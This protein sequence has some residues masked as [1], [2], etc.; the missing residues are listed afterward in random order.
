MN[1]YIKIIILFLIFLSSCA[2]KQNN[3]VIS[4]NFSNEEWARFDYL[5]GEFEITKA[6]AV[7]N[8]VMEITVS[9]VYPNIYPYHQDDGSFLFNMTIKS[10]ENEGFRSRDYK[11]RLKDKE[12]N[13]KADKVDGY[14][15]FHLPIINDITFSETG[16]YRFIIENKYTKNPLFGIKDLTLKCLDTK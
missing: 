5:N 2:K 16:V 6:P 1:R 8:I 7:Y 10:P 3:I 13:W 11:F 4:K 14:Y 15:T 9:E 12:G